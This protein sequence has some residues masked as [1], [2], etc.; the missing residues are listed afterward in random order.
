VRGGVVR[1]LRQNLP[2]FARRIGVTMLLL[3]DH[4]ALELGVSVHR[5]EST[6]REGDWAAGK[7]IRRLRRATPELRRR[8][9]L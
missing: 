8:A 6:R 5:G 2:Q 3:K 4:R 1:F 9:Q 7:G